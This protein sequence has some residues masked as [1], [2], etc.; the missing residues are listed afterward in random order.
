MKHLLLILM[1]LAIAFCIVQALPFAHIHWG[2]EYPG[3][4]QQAFGFIIIFYVIGIGAAAIYLFAT[5]LWHFF[6]RARSQFGVFAADILLGVCFVGLLGY[7][8]ITATYSDTSSS[9]AATQPA[10]GRR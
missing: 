2:H 7:Y 9:A 8:G 3:D 6:R 10:T 5:S 1:R 4:G